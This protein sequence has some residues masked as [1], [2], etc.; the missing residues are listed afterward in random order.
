[1]HWTINTA[2]NHLSIS[3][4]IYVFVLYIALNWKV[5]SIIWIQLPNIRISQSLIIV[6]LC[7]RKPYWN[8]SEWL[9]SICIE[10]F[11][12]QV[13]GILFTYSHNIINIPT[14]T[15]THFLL[16]SLSSSSSLRQEEGNCSARAH[17]VCRRPSTFTIRLNTNVIIPLALPLIILHILQYQSF[18]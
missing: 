11:H 14:Y 18:A 15:N 6:L 1:M 16:D 7:S 8:R 5:N 9:F 13:D 12:P 10:S 17:I 3:F 4:A 2:T